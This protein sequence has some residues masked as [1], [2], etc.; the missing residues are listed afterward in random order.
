MSVT[1]TSVLPQNEADASP[2][3]LRLRL[4]E[5]LQDETRASGASTGRI[6]ELQRTMAERPSASLADVLAKLRTA[7][8]GGLRADWVDRLDL[9]LIE[10]A[11]A[12]LERLPAL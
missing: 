12:D 7:R 11:I 2:A 3:I 10:S 1:K 4:L 9:K 8:M 6:K 5:E